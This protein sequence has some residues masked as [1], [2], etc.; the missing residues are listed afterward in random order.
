MDGPFSL[1][2]NQLFFIVRVIAIARNTPIETS[3]VV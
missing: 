3:I 2:L 1:H